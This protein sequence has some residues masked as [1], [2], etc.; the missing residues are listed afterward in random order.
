MS[1]KDSMH[2]SEV[3]D[4]TGANVLHDLDDMTRADWLHA[5]KSGLG[6]SDAA[7]ILGVSPWTSGY[8]LWRDKTSDH[9]DDQSSLA[10]RR[11]THLEPFILAEAMVAD[12]DLTVYR[13]PYMLAHP[14]HPHLRAN[15]DG[16]AQHAKRRTWGGVEAK[17]VNSFQAKHWADGP[18]AYYEAQIGHYFGCCPGLGW[19][20]VVADF[21]GDDLRVFY[22][23]RESV[24]VATIVE[25][26]LAWWQRHMVD[27]V[28]VD[29]DGHAAT[30]EAMK[31]YEPAVPEQVCTIDPG[32]A[33]YV[34]SRI[35]EARSMAAMAAEMEDAAKNELR[36][37][38][39]EASV[40]ADEADGQ[41]ATWR[42]GKDKTE[43]NWRAVAEWMADALGREMAAHDGDALDA[44]LLFATAEQTY[45][46]TKPGARVLRVDAGL[47]NLKETTP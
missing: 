43:T 12:P 37:L 19:W 32:Q 23:D 13:A 42:K 31:V 35:A 39:S 38:M 45:T 47:K 28:P 16:L 34:F 5:R 2:R 21:G 33:R 7:A 10:M 18:P 24:P 40:L 14:D 44:E 27:G 4:V 9:T 15:L 36:L 20:V 11:G 25:R 26:E 1:G 46:T 8:T 29:P 22:L 41:W 6:G 30:T 17:N 3:A